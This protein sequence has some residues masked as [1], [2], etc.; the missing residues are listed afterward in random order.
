VQRLPC[1]PHRNYYS[2]RHRQQSTFVI[3]YIAPLKSHKNLHSSGGTVSGRAPATRRSDRR[4]SA[5]TRSA[6][7]RGLGGANVTTLNCRIYKQLGFYYTH[8]MHQQRAGRHIAFMSN[9]YDRR[10]ETNDDPR[11]TFQTVPS[12]SKLHTFLLK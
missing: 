8:L 11:P 6:T 4:Y 12:N 1:R 5:T 7:F 3:R 2:T 9:G 10:A